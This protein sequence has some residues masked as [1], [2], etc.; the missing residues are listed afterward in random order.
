MP[1][2]V[3]GDLECHYEDDYF[4]D[5]WV[6]DPPV[7]LVQHGFQGGVATFQK[8][9]PAL[10][11]R[12]R[13][14]RRA[15]FAHDGTTS[16]RPDHDLSLAG[17][18]DDL[19]AFLDALGIDSVHFLGT[20]TGGMSG[21]PLAVRHPERVRSLGLL[22]CPIRTSALQTR[23][24]QNLPDD[25]RAK[26]P[27]WS[28]AIRGFGGYFAW[29]DGTRGGGPGA[30]PIEQWQRE[31]L[32]RC[33][34]AGLERYV[35]AMRDFDTERY[36]PDVGVPTLIMALTGSTVTTLEDQLRMRQ[37]IPDAEISFVEDAEKAG[38]RSS[39]RGSEVRMVQMAP[40]QPGLPRRYLS[41]LEARFPRAEGA[42]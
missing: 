9:I 34:E 36:L 22:D 25:L 33:D 5:P 27:T 13:V 39:Q 7:I 12:Y 18:A 37:C 4:G 24:V 23:L 32:S 10:A 11:S 28:D 2:V 16:G 30:G 20:H 15:L 41:F 14:I 17:L 26:Y 19:V 8:W 42:A 40:S 38:T 3:A 29:Y 1:A 31:S 35:A 6:S 21:I